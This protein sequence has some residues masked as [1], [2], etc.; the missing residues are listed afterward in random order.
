MELLEAADADVLLRLGM[1]VA[2]GGAIGLER[3][4]HGRAAGLRTMMLVCLGA[5]VITLVSGR[6]P[7]EDDGELQRAIVRVDPGR[8]AAGIVTGI[9]FLGGAVVVKL[10]DLVRGVTTA[11]SIWFAAA[12]GIAIGGGHYAVATA[13]TAAGL[14]V[15]WLFQFVERAIPVPVYR[16]LVVHSSGPPSAALRQQLADIFQGHRL[17]L[18][19]VSA[20]LDR[21]THTSTMT[22]HIRAIQRQQAADVVAE[23][24]HLE[25]VERV[26]WSAT[27]E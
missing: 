21:E 23:A 6:L 16:R 24:A 25:G 15:L 19:D 4:L 9:G 14:T 13:A 17:R 5:T 20:E 11:A 10:G 3:E 22:F 7:N 1:A 2:Y 26:S 18:M 12:L 8:I 27:V